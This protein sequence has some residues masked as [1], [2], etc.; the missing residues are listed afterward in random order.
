M[1]FFGNRWD[2]IL[3]DD[4][5]SENYRQLRQF[6]REE[7][8]Q[9]PVY[10][11]MEDIFNALKTTDYDDVKVL[12]LGQDPYHGPGQAH[13]NAVSV[14]R[15]VNTP[16]SLQNIY[17]ELQS[18]LGCAVPSHGCLLEWAEQGVLLLNT[19]LT[20]RDGQANSH[21]NRGWELFT[22][23]IIRH[24]D[25]REKPLVFLLWGGNAKQKLPLIRG[26]QHLVLAAAHPSPLSAY[27]GFFG[28]RHFSKA[29]AFLQA[30]G[31]TP[32]DWQI[33]E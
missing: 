20:V 25:A 16:P 18:D 6:L 8:A 11:P 26:M 28:C 2:D 4:L 5:E 12:L 17:K 14:Q 15:G 27:N 30:G 24:L 31:Q 3:K 7:Y 29:N 22:D 13:G 1:V 21:R 19:V 9:G 10:P 33:H 23:S 32:I